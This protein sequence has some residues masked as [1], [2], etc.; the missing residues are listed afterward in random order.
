MSMSY[1]TAAILTRHWESF[2]FL[3]LFNNVISSA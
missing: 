2:L 1:S 3:K